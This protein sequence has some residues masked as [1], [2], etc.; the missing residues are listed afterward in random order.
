MGRTPSSQAGTLESN[1]IFIRMS[2]APEGEEGSI[3]IESIVMKQFG[4]DILKTITQCLQESGLTG[5]NVRANDRGA[6]KCTIMARMEAAA[7]RYKESIK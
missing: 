1:D 2:Q 7:M 5:V 4:E 6:L 3:S